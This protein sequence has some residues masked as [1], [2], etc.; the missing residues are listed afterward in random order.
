MKLVWDKTINFN[1]YYRKALVPAVQQGLGQIAG[2]MEARAKQT[3]P[4][5]DRTG[6]ARRGLHGYTKRVGPTTWAAVLSH[7]RMI[8]YGPALEA[9]S[10]SSIVEPT[11]RAFGPQVF[12]AIRK[13]LLIK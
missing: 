10:R 9:R 5:T 6:A 4:W 2:Q 11:L 1:A 12:P 13:F 7:G 8:D 3:A